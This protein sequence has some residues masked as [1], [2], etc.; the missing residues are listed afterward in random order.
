MNVEGL[1]LAA[2][3][4]ATALGLV[5]CSDGPASRLVAS[6]TATPTPNAINIPPRLATAVRTPTPT[7]PALSTP[8]REPATPTRVPATPTSVPASPEIVAVCNGEWAMSFLCHDAGGMDGILVSET[9]HQWV[10]GYENWDRT[11]YSI[12]GA[13]AVAEAHLSF[14]GL[15]PGRHT[16]RVM[17]ASPSGSGVWSEPYEFL[18]RPEPQVVSSSLPPASAETDGFLEQLVSYIPMSTTAICDLLNWGLVDWLS[19]FFP[20]IGIATQTLAPLVSDFL[21]C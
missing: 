20:E 12:D 14:H 17:E 3:L 19:I 11:F 15:A 9:V 18:V 13:P 10:H 8:T 2:C 5:A 16:I 4:L 21:R 1:F 6:P 7:R